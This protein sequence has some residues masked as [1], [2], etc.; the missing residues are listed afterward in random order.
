SKR[1]GSLTLEGLREE[2]RLEPLALISMMARLGASDPIEPRAR[3]EEVVAGFDLAR[4]GRAPARFDLEELSLLN[5]KVLRESDYALM[6][7]RLAAVEPDPAR[8]E[9][10]WEALRG[11][12]ARFDDIADWAE[13]AREGAAPLVEPGDEAF[14][15]EAL[16]LLAPPPWGAEAWSE[17]SAA[18]KSATGRKGKALFM[19]LRKA[20][21]GRARGP[22]MSAFM[23]LM[24]TPPKPP[25]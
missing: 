15:A 23:P 5:A 6:A 16:A 14:V 4:F 24:R 9:P 12:V 21:T 7:E 1:L 17:W 2:E 8:A 18:V 19:P 10:L 22:E 13:I 3:L 20:L 25:A 11:N